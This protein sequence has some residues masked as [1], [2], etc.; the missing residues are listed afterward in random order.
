MP[1]IPLTERF[2][3]KKT[4]AE[5]QTPF[6]TVGLKTVALSSL[7]SQTFCLYTAEHVVVT[8]VIAAF[9]GNTF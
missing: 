6:D 1:L 3:G 5:F 9:I 4:C 7:V 2:P 8:N